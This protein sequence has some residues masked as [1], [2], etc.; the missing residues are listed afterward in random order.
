MGKILGE[1]SSFWCI[2]R[3]ESH[4]VDR[5]FLMNKFICETLAVSAISGLE[6]FTL[7]EELLLTLD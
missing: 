6:P 1:T 4:C 7:L 5:L 2:L 3:L